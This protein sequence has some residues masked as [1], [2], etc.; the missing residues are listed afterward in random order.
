MDKATILS[1]PA[2]D[3]YTVAMTTEHH[4]H[5]RSRQINADFMVSTSVDDLQWHFKDPS[6]RRVDVKSV[7]IA[8]RPEDV[9]RMVQIFPVIDKGRYT[10]DPVHKVAHENR[11]VVMMRFYDYNFVFTSGGFVGD[12]C[13]TETWSK[14][15][16]I[17]WQN[18]DSDIL[19]HTR[20]GAGEA[21][22][23]QY[24]TRKIAEQGDE[25]RV[26]LWLPEE[27]LEF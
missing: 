10:G 3:F 9:N 7:V 12:K 22:L 25:D 23:V 17:L 4:V 5:F 20:P 26:M 18:D 13:R 1:Y 2:C 24:N 21:T 16:S 11:V 19:V 8:G 14:E 6:G 15:A 27:Q